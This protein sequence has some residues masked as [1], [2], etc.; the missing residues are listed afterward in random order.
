MNRLV[1]QLDNLH[2]DLQARESSQKQL[3]DEVL[4]MEN[5]IMQTLAEARVSKDCQLR[6]ILDEV[7]PRNIEKINKLLVTKDEEVS[8]LKEEVRIMSDHW[9]LKTKELESQA[10]RI[11]PFFIFAVKFPAVAVLP[12]ACELIYF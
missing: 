7:S 12:V 5:D 6:K 3:K 11:I 2:R 10:S 1:E 8:R 4:R 9:K